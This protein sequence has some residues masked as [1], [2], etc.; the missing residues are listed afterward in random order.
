MSLCSASDYFR[1]T[2]DKTDRAPLPIHSEALLRE[3]SPLKRL[4]RL[5]GS[6]QYP[7]GQLTTTPFCVPHTTRLPCCSTRRDTRTTITLVTATLET[8]QT[9]SENHCLEG[10]KSKHTSCSVR[11]Y[12]W[13]RLE[14]HDAVPACECM[15][16]KWRTLSLCGYLHPTV[17]YRSLL[18]TLQLLH[19]PRSLSYAVRCSRNLQHLYLERYEEENDDNMNTSSP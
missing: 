17:L 11:R 15:C 12:I 10:H 1:D 6:F 19:V 14:K 2:T 7:Q 5:L 4:A 13:I 8:H 16:Q 9:S 18:F 3:F